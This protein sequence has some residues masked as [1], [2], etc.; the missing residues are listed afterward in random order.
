MHQN[1][2][3]I[4]Q[5]GASLVVS[6][7]IG[8]RLP[9]AEPALTVCMQH[10]TTLPTHAHICIRQW[11]FQP[12]LFSGLILATASDCCQLQL[13]AVD[14]APWLHQMGMEFFTDCQVFTGAENALSPMGLLQQ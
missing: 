5:P 7:G 2:A 4:L 14:P 9:F 12:Q 6:I 13:F 1:K 8:R 3:V 11:L 10:S